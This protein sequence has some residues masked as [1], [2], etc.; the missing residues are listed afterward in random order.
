MVL[1]EDNSSCQLFG[2]KGIELLH[3]SF[4]DLG[5][6]NQSPAQFATEME[7]WDEHFKSIH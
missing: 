4:K 1:A 7:S 2:N 3:G 5:S 6:S